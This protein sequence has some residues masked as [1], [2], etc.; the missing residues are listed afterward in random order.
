MKRPILLLTITL[1]AVTLEAQFSVGT[2]LV[3]RYI[4]RGVDYGNAAA[5][6]PNIAY[7]AGNFSIGAWGSFGLSAESFSE[8]DL[9]MSYSFPFG[10][11]L[12]L[13]DYYYPGTEWGEFGDK[14]S[15]HALELIMGYETKGLSLAGHY[16]LNN[17]AEGIGTEDGTLYFE[18]GYA[19]A[20]V[21]VFVGA[22]DGWHSNNGD[23][24]LVNIGIATSKEIKFTDS[25]SLPLFGQLITN[26]NSEQL[27][28]VVGISL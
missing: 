20:K 12:G 27:Y 1:A 15:S 10:L 4:Y 28:I 11:S 14:I 7:V 8:A 22:G 23:F 26:P 6:Q 13:T 19:F 5:I 18:A 3:S 25:F 24:E 21:D 2:D 17:S 9:Y 16:M